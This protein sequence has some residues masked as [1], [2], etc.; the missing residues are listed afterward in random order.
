MTKNEK[1]QVAVF[2]F[3]VISDFV[4]GVQISRNEKRQL[5]AEKCA[6]KWQIPFSEKTQISKGTIKRW[7]RLYEGSNGELKSLC[8]K[9]RSDRGR[10]RSM[11]DD[12]CMELISLRK[13][14]PVATVPQLIEQ[15]NQRKL[16]TPCL[17]YTSPSP[18]D[19]GS[20]LV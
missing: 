13:E 14:I 2:R 7:C 9:D 10:S 20:N 3:G 15:V 5:L 19:L 8:P 1:M 17:L 11:D 6:R 4:T 12:T 16:V 18:R